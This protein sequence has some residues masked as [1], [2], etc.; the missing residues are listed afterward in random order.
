[1]AGNQHVPIPVDPSSAG[2]SS[3][4]IIKAPDGLDLY[5]KRYH[6]S[7]PSLPALSVVFVHG[8]VEYIARYEAAFPAFSARSIELI[9]FDQR[10]FGQTAQ[11]APGGWGK[12]YTTTNWPQQ[13]MDVQAVVVEQRKYL[14]DKFGKDKV[15]IYL[16]GHSMGGGISIAVFTRDASSPEHKDLEQ[17]RT[18]VKGVAAS[19]PWLTL[20]KV[21]R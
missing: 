13:F 1:M 8:F 12:H 5:F 4:G 14:D 3:E 15:P 10:G 18:I 7:S 19:S 17:L 21:R 16:L 9:A 11:K 20:T 2:T 6:P